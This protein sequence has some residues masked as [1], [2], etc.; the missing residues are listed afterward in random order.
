MSI[1]VDIIALIQIALYGWQILYNHPLILNVHKWNL[2]Y[3]ST[4]V[5]NINNFFIYVYIISLSSCRIITTLLCFIFIFSVFFLASLLFL[6]LLLLCVP[7]F[8]LSNSHL[9]LLLRVISFCC[10]W[11]INQLKQHNNIKLTWNINNNDY[12]FFTRFS[13][14]FLYSSHN[15]VSQS[16]SRVRR[17]F[18]TI[19]TWWCD[20]MIE[21][22]GVEIE[23]KKKY[24]T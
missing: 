4:A 8:L 10:W 13:V 6:L 16:V 24:F 22:V 19:S 21:N 9:W 15:T 17:F 7:H 14:I 18:M 20:I 1:I 23:N 11:E 12:I 2:K 5:Y 3:H